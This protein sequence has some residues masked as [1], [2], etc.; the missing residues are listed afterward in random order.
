MGLHVGMSVA[1]IPQIHLGYYYS[2][3]NL[4]GQLAKPI[5]KNPRMSN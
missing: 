2:L 3:N 5:L 4:V 1:K